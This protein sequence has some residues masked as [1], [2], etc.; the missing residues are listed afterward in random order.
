M[1]LSRLARLVL[2]QIPKAQRPPNFRKLLV[3]KVTIS[4]LAERAHTIYPAQLISSANALD[5]VEQLSDD[6]SATKCSAR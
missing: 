1:K 5:R 6:C 3:S 4:P 2:E